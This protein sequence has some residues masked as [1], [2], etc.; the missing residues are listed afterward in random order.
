MPRSAGSTSPAWGQQSCLRETG[1]QLPLCEDKCANATRQPL[2]YSSIP[3]YL[4]EARVSLIR[5]TELTITTIKATMFACMPLLNSQLGEQMT[6]A[7]TVL[8]RNIQEVFTCDFCLSNFYLSSK[9]SS[10]KS[11]FRK[12]SLPRSLF[13]V[14]PSYL[15]TVSCITSVCVHIR[16]YTFIDIRALAP[17]II[18]CPCTQKCLGVDC[19]GRAILCVTWGRSPSQ[20]IFTSEQLYFLQDRL[21]SCTLNTNFANPPTLFGCV[22]EVNPCS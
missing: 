6:F 7:H 12:G 18:R 14:C 17:M 5:S 3:V 2:Q 4:S 22:I 11:V 20:F 10:Q 9:V 15:H 16:V 1:C 21:K 13:L 19:T 8:A